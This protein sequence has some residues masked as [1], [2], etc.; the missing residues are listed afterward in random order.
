MDGSGTPALVET[1]VRDG[2]VR[3]GGSQLPP[4]AANRYVDLYVQSSDSSSKA[5]MTDS[6]QP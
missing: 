2:M 5:Y 1:L 4:V 6:H 3:R